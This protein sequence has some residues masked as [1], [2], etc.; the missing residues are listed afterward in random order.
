MTHALDLNG[1]RLWNMAERT[2]RP[3][4]RRRQ[5]AREEGQGWFSPDFQ[6]GL[7]L[8]V[9]FVVLH[10]YLPFSGRQLAKMESSI[11]ALSTGP[12]FAVT[13]FSAVAVAVH[14]LIVVLAPI[15]LPL[16]GVGLAAALAQ[17]GLRLTLSRLAP[18]FSRLDPFA[19]LA[20]MFSSQSLWVLAK[21]FLK[22]GV[23]GVA[24]GLAMA[25]N[26]H[27]YAEL[28]VL[29]L[30]QALSDSGTLLSGI[31]IRAAA[32]YFV[33]GAIDAGY[34]YYSFQQSLRMSTDE[35]RDE[36]KEIEGDPKIRGRRRQLHRKLIQTG[37]RE[38][39]NASVIVTNPTHY[40]VAL[41]WDEKTMRAPVVTA[42]GADDVALAMREIAYQ[43]SI[44]LVENPPLA[45]SLYL[46]PLG[47]SIREEHYQAV[48]DILAFIIRRRRG[49]WT[50]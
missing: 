17:R 37:M 11:L 29:P 18:D 34:Q 20:R 6:A 39:K 35:V 4:P 45:R 50:S 13:W 33:I 12:D 41:K 21:G 22:M 43:E 25:E 32:A 47:E 26:L 1:V 31:L 10:W 9:A 16:G 46:V 48:A 23:I 44:P 14:S 28:I 2:Q 42:K 19:G 38:V 30:G 24:V 49:G 5:R 36:M 3:T 7:A 40:A 27:A 8:L 15:A